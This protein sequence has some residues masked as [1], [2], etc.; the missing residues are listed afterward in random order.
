M[1]AVLKRNS[2]LTSLY[3]EGNNSLKVKS[4]G[5]RQWNPVERAYE[6]LPA[7]PRGRSEIVNCLFDTSSLKSIV[8]SN[9]TCMVACGSSVECGTR[10]EKLMNKINSLANVGEK[11]RYKVVL[12]LNETE[13]L[14]NVRDFDSV[15]L[16]LIPRLLELI[17][18]EV[19]Y[20]GFGEDIVEYLADKKY[21]KDSDM[22]I[23]RLYDFVTGSNTQLLFERGSGLKRVRIGPKKKR[24]RRR[25]IG[26]S[27]DED[28]EDFKPPRGLVVKP[29]VK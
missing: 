16:E 9:H 22:R 21:G 4:G 27:C 7:V 6:T 20:Y 1:C 19:G 5:R 26:F 12:A 25:K 28:D 24:K 11:I 15:P 10:I 8:D 14:Y 3:L 17:Q 2:T 23:N 13:G 29:Y 18:L